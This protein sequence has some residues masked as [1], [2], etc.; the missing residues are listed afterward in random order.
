MH[1]TDLLQ[2]LSPAA[3]CVLAASLMFTVPGAG[4]AEPSPDA[5]LAEALRVSLSAPAEACGESR[6][7]PRRLAPF[8]QL[9]SPR[10]LWVSHQGPGAR[11]R[12]LRAALRTAGQHGLERRDARPAAGAA[13]RGAGP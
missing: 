6:L 7:D 4:R 1:I 11:A 9:A 12:T 2:R 3:R 8:Y 13:R 10:P 5:A